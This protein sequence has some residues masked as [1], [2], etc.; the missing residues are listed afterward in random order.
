MKQRRND[1][2]P[3]DRDDAQDC[4]LC[5]CHLLFDRLR[6]VR[7]SAC[8]IGFPV[9]RRYLARAILAS[10]HESRRI[11]ARSLHVETDNEPRERR[12]THRQRL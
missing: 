1:S 9:K 5:R 3:R 4:Q 10:T 8:M 6:I 12:A 11:Q 2:L 7:A